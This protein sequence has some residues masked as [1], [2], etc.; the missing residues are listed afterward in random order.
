M[1]CL[2]TATLW[3]MDAGELDSDN[4]AVA[5]HHARSCLVCEHARR[6][7]AQTRQLLALADSAPAAISWRSVDTAIDDALTAAAA[8]SFSGAA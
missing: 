2:D 3:A 1:S 8:R 7:L 5:L 6:E 4:L